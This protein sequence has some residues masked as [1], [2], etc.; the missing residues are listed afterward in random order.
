ML[1]YYFCLF[2]HYIENNKMA[3]LQYPSEANDVVEMKTV[4]RFHVY[5]KYRGKRTY[6]CT[7][8]RGW[9]KEIN[10]ICVPLFEPEKSNVFAIVSLYLV[11][12]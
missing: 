1:Y 7:G 3:I 10:Q 4:I 11:V 2:Y 9:V 6:W 5:F 8:C 12:V